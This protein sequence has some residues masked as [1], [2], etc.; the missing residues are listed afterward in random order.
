MVTIKRGEHTLVVTMGAYKSL[1]KSMGYVLTGAR[2]DSRSSSAPV[3]VTT[4]PDY[5][6]DC[7]SEPESYEEEVNDD[8]EEK[9]LSEMSFKELKDY[10]D[11]LGINTNGVSSK[12]EIRMAIRK[13]VEG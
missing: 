13:L 3:R 4:D 7:V 12:K 10:A 6:E 1:Y 11:R 9:P 5:D 8:M 2:E